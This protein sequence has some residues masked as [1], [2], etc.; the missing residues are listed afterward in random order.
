MVFDGQN[1][2]LLLLDGLKQTA[3]TDKQGFV[4]TGIA[5]Q[6]KEF[7]GISMKTGEFN[8]VQT[9]NGTMWHRLAAVSNPHIM[10]PVN[11]SPSNFQATHIMSDPT[12]M[13]GMHKY[14]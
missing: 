13:L 4:K 5:F 14:F 3:L 9:C 10:A 11:Q 2:G 6:R 1:I 7:T 12:Q 8:P